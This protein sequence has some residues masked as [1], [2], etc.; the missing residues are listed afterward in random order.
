MA[1]TLDL[2]CWADTVGSDWTLPLDPRT[3]GCW[4]IPVQSGSF[5]YMGSLATS[6]PLCPRWLP[7]GR[8][9][10][11]VPPMADSVHCP[12]RGAGTGDTN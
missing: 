9:M 1:E 6:P 7:V 5:C 10:G 11:P 3:R 4:A 2:V 8:H 12:T